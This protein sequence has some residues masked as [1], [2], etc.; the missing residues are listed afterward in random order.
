MVE[1]KGIVIES[2]NKK[3]LQQP[4]ADG[5]WGVGGG[6]GFLVRTS[7]KSLDQNIAGLPQIDLISFIY[8][9]QASEAS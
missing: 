4:G 6:G 3:T 8:N 1:I 5:G 7:Y 2:A 9:S